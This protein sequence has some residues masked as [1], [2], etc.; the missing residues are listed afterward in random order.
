MGGRHVIYAFV[1]LTGVAAYASAQSYGTFGGRTVGNSVSS[2][3][4][5]QSGGSPAFGMSPGNAV[6][7]TQQN[8][9]QVTGNE[10]FVRG[11]RPAGAFVGADSGDAQNFF[12]QLQGNAGNFGSGLN[13]NRNRTERGN[14]MPAQTTPVIRRRLH[15][16]FEY[17]S[18]A[19]SELSRRLNSRLQ[20]VLASVS[21]QSEPYPDV[22]VAMLDAT[23]VLRGT[24][25]SQEAK[26]L[27]ERLV[28]LEPGV[29]QVQNELVVDDPDT[30]PD[31]FG[32]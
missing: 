25:P 3:G 20:G 8:A 26:L 6:G 28:R 5:P 30:S 7:Q 2:L 31:P 27:L 14:Q 24:V 19:T 22:Q 32:S 9:G 12:S 16:G 17:Q 11:A 13:A 4:S 21:R 10:R 15:V 29:W 23:V 18:P 1:L